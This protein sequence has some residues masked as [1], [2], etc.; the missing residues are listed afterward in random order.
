M[1]D[2]YWHIVVP[3]HHYHHQGDHQDQQ[4]QHHR[5]H[6]SHIISMNN[7]NWRHWMSSLVD[8]GGDSAG[9]QCLLLSEDSS[10]LPHYKILTSTT[11]P[12]IYLK[13]YH[14]APTWYQTTPPSYIEESSHLPHCH[15]ASTRYQTKPPCVHSTPHFISHYFLLVSSPHPTIHLW[16]ALY[17]PNAASFVPIQFSIPY[18]ICITHPVLPY[19]SVP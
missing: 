3:P 16:H 14:T 11:L 13:S 15:T 17:P 4:Q 5:H 1:P 2:H 7:H 10:H 9:P 6:R 8:Q 12:H 19:H 18:H